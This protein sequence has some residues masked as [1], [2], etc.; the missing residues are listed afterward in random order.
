MVADPSVVLPP[1]LFGDND[2]ALFEPLAEA[3]VDGHKS[4]SSGPS[5]MTLCEDLVCL[6][7]CVSVTVMSGQ[8]WGDFFLTWGFE[9]AHSR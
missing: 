3:E 1:C 7:F 2:S 6:T 9:R 4:G 8:D 5:C